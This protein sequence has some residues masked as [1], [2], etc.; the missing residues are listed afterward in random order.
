M[1]ILVLLSHTVR[2]N[3]HFILRIVIFTSYKLIDGLL[4][5]RLIGVNFSN[6]RNVQNNLPATASK[7]TTE[8]LVYRS[9]EV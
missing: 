9:P 3:M 6:F 2:T 8:R 7:I 4:N 5:W 1:Y